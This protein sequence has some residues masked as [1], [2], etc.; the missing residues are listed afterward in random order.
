MKPAA[1]LIA[2]AAALA[3]ST[4]AILAPARAA[5]EAPDALVKRVVTGMSEAV[6]AD[7][8][9]LAGDRRQLLHLVERDVLPY[10]DFQR[11]TSLAAGRFWR[12]ATPE[13]QRQLVSEFRE[14]LTQ[15]YADA[16]AQVA[17]G[18]PESVPLRLH[19][20]DTDAE[21]IVRFAMADGV[22]RTFGYR[23]AKTS[24]GWWKIFDIRMM[25]AWLVET[26]K[27]KFAA[28]IN[29]GGVDGLIHALAVRNHQW[30]GKSLASP[31]P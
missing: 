5:E 13:Q 17:G 2:T 11:M 10:A 22:S 7:P 8:A 27:G 24:Y 15:T 14:L 31:R 21:V 30:R 29:R 28:E 6:K 4:T 23:L 18:M 12:Q 25:D 26:E 19:P 20:A 16:L 9:A 1:S 3:F